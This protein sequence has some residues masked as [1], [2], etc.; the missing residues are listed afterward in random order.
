MI[1]NHNLSSINTNRVMGKVGTQIDKSL[2]K[3]SSGMRINRG[4]DDASGLAVSEKMRAQIRGLGQA[5]KNARDGSSFIRTAEGYLDES[6]KILHRIREL[7]VQAANGI[8]SD[9]DRAQIQTEVDQLVM[10]IDRIASHA[11]FNGMNILTGRF[12]DDKLGGTPS[13]SM[14][15]HVGAN[16]DQRI[17]AYI[18]TMSAKGLKVIHPDTEEKISLSSPEKANRTLGLVDQALKRLVKQRAEL[19]AV[20]NRLDYVMSSVDIGAENLQ[21]AESLIRDLDMAQQVSEM[22]KDQ[23]LHQAG[24]AMLSQAN[25]KGQGIL[26][27]LGG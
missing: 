5:S 24:I 20:Q 19:G 23:I 15:F 9:E 18:G 27:L 12:A 6:T 3:I 14:W 13:A 8:Y 16:M 21:A 22:V 25:T 4:G 11:T 1:V 26:R 2:E 17:R 10:E 7:G